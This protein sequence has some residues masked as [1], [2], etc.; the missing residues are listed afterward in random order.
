[1]VDFV[2]H[3]VDDLFAWFDDLAACEDISDHLEELTSEKL[4]KL[5]LDP[6]EPFSDE[7]FQAAVDRT[8]WKDLYVLAHLAN[9]TPRLQ[10]VYDVIYYGV[11]HMLLA[12]TPDIEED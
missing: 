3:I 12:C 8:C 1:M 9:N 2:I 5:M 11:A 7:L 10:Y 4:S 6:D